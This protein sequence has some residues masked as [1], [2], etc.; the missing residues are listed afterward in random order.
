MSL[1]DACILRMAEINDRHVVLTLDSDF[2]VYRKHRRVA[3]AV[4]RALGA[5]RVVVAVPVA[6]V[7]IVSHLDGADEVVCVGSPRDFRAVSL[8]YSEFDQVSEDRKSVV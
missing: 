3:L 6:P 4:V 5:S 2:L 7:E 8:Y 1:A